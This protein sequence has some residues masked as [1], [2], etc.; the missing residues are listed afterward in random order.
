MGGWESALVESLTVNV[1]SAR[2]SLIP[3]PFMGEKRAWYTLLVHVPGNGRYPDSMLA[4]VDPTSYPKPYG[5]L[6]PY[7]QARVT[8]PNPSDGSGL[9]MER[10]KVTP[11]VGGAVLPGTH[12]QL[13]LQ[14]RENLS[15]IH[16]YSTITHSHTR[17]QM[18][19]GQVIWPLLFF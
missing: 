14:T 5:P 4:T 12:T 18:T 6:Q 3:R 8:T 15:E 9:G 16:H 13:L 17:T 10:S 1:L 2:L 7:K 11:D 19:S